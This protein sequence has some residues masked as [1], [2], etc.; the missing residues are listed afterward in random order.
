MLSTWGSSTGLNSSS[1]L[2]ADLVSNLTLTKGTGTFT[3]TRATVATVTDFEGRVIPVKSGEARFTGARRVENLLTSSDTAS[4][5]TPT[6]VVGTY[7]LTLGGGTGSITATGVG[8]GTLG[9][10]A[11]TRK[12]MLITTTAGGLV[13]TVTGTVTNWILEN[14][15]G[16]TNQNPS[17]YVSSSWNDTG[18]TGVRYFPTTNGN[19]VASNVVTEGIGL[20]IGTIQGTYK[21]ADNCITNGDYFSTP[22]STASS[23]TG[24]IS[25]VIEVAPTSW[26]PASA[27]TFCSKDDTSAG[28]R[29]YGIVL[30]PSGLLRFKFSIDGTNIINVDSTVAP[31]GVTNNVKMHIGA[32]RNAATGDVTFWSSTSHGNWTQVG[33]TVSST[34]GAIYASTAPVTFGSRTLTSLVLNGKLF[35]SEVYSGLYFTSHSTATLKVDFDPSDWV[36]GAT[37]TA[38]DTGEVWT[39]NGNARIYAPT[40]NG[41]NSETSRTNSIYPSGNTGAVAGSPGTLPNNWAINGTGYTGL[42]R[43]VVGTGTQD[44]IPYT[45]V[46]IYGTS[47]A[48]GALSFI[49]QNGYF[50]STSTSVNWNIAYYAA[51]VGGNLP[52]GTS[53]IYINQFLTGVYVS[54]MTLSAIVL[55]SN[56]IRRVHNPI[57]TAAAGVNQISTLG[58]VFNLSASTAYDFTLRVGGVQLELGAFSTSYIPTTSVEYTRNADVLSIPSASN[59]LVLSPYTIRCEAYVNAV[60]QPQNAIGSNLNYAANLNVSV[61]A[62]NT[63]QLASSTA[64]SGA[65][66]ANTTQTTSH[67][68][69]G[70]MDGTNVDVF[71]DGTKGTGAAKGTQTSEISTIYIGCHNSASQLNGNVKNVKI[72]QTAFGDDKCSG[73]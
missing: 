71:M 51:I 50:V 13:L 38:L 27:N 58:W 24:D 29:S 45:D 59:L 39:I 35:D 55:N 48:G 20:P 18:A 22:S 26:T 6:V 4:T 54:T 43:T 44:G 19:T 46:R 53:P 12:S 42:S 47:T 16:Q 3:F 65:T 2:I 21:W 69:V 34:A 10:S 70:R 14:V 56:F 1:T 33:T 36:S 28:T 5:Q 31:S 9:A 62:A 11:T 67:R 25:F 8:S 37:W 7:C 32:Q 64:L 61:S 60:A 17:E 73:I 40:L 68:F 63:S 66:I 49:L 23:I 57:T 52:N 72:Y 15:T 30:L 41:F